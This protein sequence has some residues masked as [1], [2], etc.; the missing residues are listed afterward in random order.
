MIEF[1]AIKGAEHLD[2]VIFTD[3]YGY[4]F[5]GTMDECCN[6]ADANDDGNTE[7]KAVAVSKTN[8]L[9]EVEYWGTDGLSDGSPYDYIAQKKIAAFIIK[10][11]I[12]NKMNM[13]QYETDFL[14]RLDYETISKNIKKEVEEKYLNKIVDINETDAEIKNSIIGYLQDYSDFVSDEWDEENGVIVIANTI[15]FEDSVFTGEET[16]TYALNS[17]PVLQTK[18]KREPDGKTA[19]LISVEIKNKSRAKKI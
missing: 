10:A 19:K 13:T 18:Y 15:R 6:F 9:E 5:E 16:S 4:D 14:D 11:V 3:S 1:Y 12:D 7:F 2:K 8:S 17:Y